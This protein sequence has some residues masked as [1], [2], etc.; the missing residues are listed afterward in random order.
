MIRPGH[1]GGA[2]AL[3]LVPGGRSGPGQ[4]PGPQR[5]CS[6]SHPELSEPP[7]GPVSSQLAL[8]GSRAPSLATLGAPWGR[9][10]AG[11]APHHGAE[12]LAAHEQRLGPMRLPASRDELM[13][14][15]VAAGVVG[16][17]GGEFPLS[18]KLRTAAAAAGVAAVPLVVVNG[19]EGE[20]ASRKDRTLLEHR[21]HLV[22]D[23]AEV[24]AAA[25]G[26]PDVVVYVHVGR[27]AV[28][29][30]LRR[31]LDERAATRRPGP[32]VHLVEA[33]DR[34]VAGESSAVVSVLEGRGPLPSR[35]QVP[36][37][38]AGVGGR[39][40]VVTNVE[41]VAHLA[42]AVRFGADWFAEAGTV[43]APGSTLLTL[44][45]GVAVPGLVV[46]V[47]GPATFGEV[48]DGHGGWDRP[49]SAVLVGGYEGRWVDGAALWPAPVD[50]PALRAAG[51]ALGCGLVAPLPPGTCGLAVTA[52]LVRY[53]AGESAGQCGPCVYGLPALADALGA[54]AAGRAGRGEIR[55]LARAAVSARGSGDCGHPDGVADLIESALHVLA[56]DVHAHIRRGTCGGRS[57]GWFPIPGDGGSGAGGG[58]GGG[59]A[60]RHG[61]SSR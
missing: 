5:P 40:T 20:P 30:A 32:Q 56:D 21:P 58:A 29:A 19:S 27:P 28:V 8:A 14:E 36:V 24:A 6:G 46:E 2:P 45:G 12:D 43:G 53:L 42:L 50:R 3:R 54:V 10:L 39:P 13:E 60:G 26:A 51:M 11:P 23:G 52:R 1:G 35:R 17:G 59:G 33:P 49:P 31:A 16:R 22:L 47:V 34:Y 4:G 48:L 37:A 9:L 57:G 44:A 55:R 25:A 7:A 18:A 41:S 61:G 15:V 38:V